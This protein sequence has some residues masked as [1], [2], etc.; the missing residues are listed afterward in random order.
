MNQR[1]MG[2]LRFPMTRAPV[3]KPIRSSGV[4]IEMLATALWA[5]SQ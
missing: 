3:I 5:I 4:L 1:H 2:A